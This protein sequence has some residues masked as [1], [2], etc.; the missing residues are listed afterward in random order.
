LIDKAVV[1]IVKGFADVSDLAW[2]Y[3]KEFDQS[4][5]YLGN[6]LVRAL[7]SIGAN[8]CE[9]Y[10]REYPGN[11]AQFYRYA[12]GSGLE[13]GWWLE[14][15]MARRLLPTREGNS[16]LVQLRENLAELDV[17]IGGIKRKGD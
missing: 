17:L 12:R 9:G 1:A 4:A 10:G 7:D 14:R 3:V 15:A 6:Q 11:V 13:A 2:E 8:I 5:G 16:M